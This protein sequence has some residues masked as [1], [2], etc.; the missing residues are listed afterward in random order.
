MKKI[1]WFLILTLI[2]IVQSS[3]RLL[4]LSSEEV[5]PLKYFEVQYLIDTYMGFL[6][7][8][9]FEKMYIVRELVLG[10]SSCLVVVKGNHHNIMMYTY[11]FIFNLLVNVDFSYYFFQKSENIIKKRENEYS[12]GQIRDKC[13]DQIINDNYQ[14]TSNLVAPGGPFF[15]GFF[16]IFTKNNHSRDLLEI[17]FLIKCFLPRII[18]WYYI[19]YYNRLFVSEFSSSKLLHVFIHPISTYTS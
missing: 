4:K 2:T 8:Y 6:K 11:T 3:N 5:N 12:W 18:L 17:Y 10:I 13:I 1:H 9:V 16:Q 14:I 7:I 15:I 19:L